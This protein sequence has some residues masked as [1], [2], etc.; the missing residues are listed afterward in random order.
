MHW[1]GVLIVLSTC[2]E[3]LERELA[4]EQLSCIFLGFVHKECNI[5]H[6]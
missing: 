6:I 5:Q 2:T 3:D 4:E 1:T